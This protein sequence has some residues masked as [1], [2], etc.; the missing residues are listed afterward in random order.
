MIGI[1]AQVSLYPL[2]QA[3]ISPAIE[4][5]LHIFQGHGLVVRPGDMSTLVNGDDE[6]VFLS[7]KE[8]F[9][10]VAQQGDIVM[11]VTF[12]NACPIS[13]EPSSPSL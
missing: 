10:Q 11:V 13:D 7:L 12:S 6:A 9:E 4:Q 5:A 8:I 1:S 2:R 3:Q